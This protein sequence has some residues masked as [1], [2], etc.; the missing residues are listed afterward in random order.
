MV[1]IR[2]K[3]ELMA[4]LLLSDKLAHLPEPPLTHFA[5]R[6]CQLAEAVTPVGEPFTLVNISTWPYENAESAHIA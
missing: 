3:P 2:P 1:I 5:F 6:V 4:S